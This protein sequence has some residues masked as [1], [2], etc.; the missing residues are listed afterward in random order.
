MTNSLHHHLLVLLH[1]PYFHLPAT[2]KL[3][4]QPQCWHFFGLFGSQKVCPSSMNLLK[5]G[6]QLS[7]KVIRFRGLVSGRLPYLKTQAGQLDSVSAT[8]YLSRNSRISCHSLESRSRKAVRKQKR[9]WA[10]QLS[11]S[12]LLIYLVK[13]Q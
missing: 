4:R 11:C 13:L 10:P 8:P 9:L 12:I 1:L 2:V 7:R 5:F 3:K 6:L